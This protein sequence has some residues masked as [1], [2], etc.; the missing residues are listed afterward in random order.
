MNFSTFL[1][2]LREGFKSLFRNGWMSI[3]S[4][5]SIIVSLLILGVFVLL[6]VNVNSMADQADDQVEISTFLQLNVDEALRG[7]LQDEIGAMPEV[8]KIEF[9]PKEQGLADF[10]EE[11]GEDGQELLEGFD[12]DN[13]PLPD[14]LR[15]EV[16]DPS[17]V[18][19]V[20]EKIEALNEEYQEQP[21]MKV[22]Y[23]K[24][25]V[26]T[27]FKITRLIRTIGVVFVAGLALMS[28]FLISNTIR[29]TIL[30]R[31]REISIMK[32]VGAT[33][34]FIRWPFFVEGALIGFIGS[35]ITIAILFI[36]YN[37]LLNSIQQDIIIQMLDLVPLSGIW[38]WFGGSLLIMGMLVGILGST[39]SIR[40]SLKV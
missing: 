5:T 7:K 17:T 23:G 33:N 1:R 34:S 24:D 22:N 6:V 39:L 37:Q 28:M 40:K 16:I 8:S 26:E 25:T 35:I 12:E 11:L 10:K 4:I 31:R 21:I 3:A 19:F 29:V 32:L 2:H 13:N 36:G 15:V 20:A 9:V 38:T 14:T 18:S 27:L 30:A